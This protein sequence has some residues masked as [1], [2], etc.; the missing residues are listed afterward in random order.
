[1]AECIDRQAAL[2]EIERREDG[3]WCEYLNEKDGDADA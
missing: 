1:M 2:S 3:R